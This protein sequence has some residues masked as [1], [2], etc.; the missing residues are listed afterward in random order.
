MKTDN[1]DHLMYR[2]KAAAASLSFSKTNYQ[3]NITRQW[4]LKTPLYFGNEGSRMYHLVE[5]TQAYLHILS[6]NEIV[7]IVVTTT[8]CDELNYTNNGKKPYMYEIVVEESHNKIR[9]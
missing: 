4:T 3:N 9:K 6:T 2:K 5:T 7:P 8:Q 1:V